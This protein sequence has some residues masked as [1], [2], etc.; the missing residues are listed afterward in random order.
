M[1]H[2]VGQCRDFNKISDDE[3]IIQLSGVIIRDFNWSILF[4]FKIINKNQNSKVI[5]YQ[6]LET[7]AFKTLERINS[8]RTY[9]TSYE[10][11][12]GTTPSAMRH[13]WLEISLRIFEVSTRSERQQKKLISLVFTFSQFASSTQALRMSSRSASHAGSWYT[14]NRKHN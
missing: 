6:Y 3:S 12:P 5:S 4:K 8:Y 7:I 13:P 1:K 2:S 10:C 11:I 9:R 14:S